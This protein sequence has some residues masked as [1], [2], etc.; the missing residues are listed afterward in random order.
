MMKFVKTLV[1]KRQKKWVNSIWVNPLTTILE[2]WDQDNL[3]IKSWNLI[4]NKKKY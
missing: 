1:K 2:S 3:I 4:L